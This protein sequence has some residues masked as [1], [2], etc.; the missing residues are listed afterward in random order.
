MAVTK[1][2]PGRYKQGEEGEQAGV[3]KCG[4]GPLGHA[5]VTIGLPGQDKTRN[6]GCVPLLHIH[7][8]SMSAV[9]HSG[10]FISLVMVISDSEG[11]ESLGI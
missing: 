11:R 10:R 2:L 4:G 1:E 9:I 5:T 3:R 6:V 7:P 8:A